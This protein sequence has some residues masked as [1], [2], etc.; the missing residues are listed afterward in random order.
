VTNRRHYLAAVIRLYLDQPD[1]PTRPSR[2]DWAVA[3]TLY[4]RGV[5]LAVLAHAVRL[6]TLRRLN[7][8][9][10][11]PVRCLAYYRSVLEQLG[12]DELDPGYVAYIARRFA[13]L[14]SPPRRSHRQNPALSGRR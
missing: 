3:H 7:T 8:P 10:A 11:T 2:Q 4:A 14:A 13:A 9:E 12:P 6:A 1:A 5:D